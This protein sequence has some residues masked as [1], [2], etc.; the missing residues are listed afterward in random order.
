MIDRPK[1]KEIAY[2][3]GHTTIP[4]KYDICQFKMDGIWG[5]L[6][7]KDGQVTIYSRTNT[8]KYEEPFP[9]P[10]VDIVLLGEYMKGSHWGHKMKIDGRF[11]AFDCVELHGFDVS[12]TAYKDR[13]NTCKQELEYI[14]MHIDWIE[15]MEV[16]D[17]DVWRELWHHYVDGEGFEGLVFKDSNS[18]YNE[19]G[20]WARMKSVVEI[21]YICIGF[22]PADKGTKYEGQVG[23]VIGT[24]IDKDVLVTCS[25]LSED[26]RT[27]FTK[28]PERYI[29]QV[30]KAKGNNWYPTGA[31]R[32]PMFRHWRDDKYPEECTYEQIPES[33]RDAYR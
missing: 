3:M 31:L 6:T 30:F 8:I 24:L 1:F 32:H 9:D 19:K 13:F 28:Y 17:V 25:G 11:Y 7:I 27:A 14:M 29:G 4:E 20:A 2:E 10:N 22:R 5:C 18:T 15:P 33:I 23:A 21:D 16:Y 12:Q 26:M